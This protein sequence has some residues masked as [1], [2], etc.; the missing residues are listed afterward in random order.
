MKSFIFAF[1]VITALSISSLYSQQALKIAVV[2][3]QKAFN[4]FYK[5]K[6]ADSEMKSKVAAFEKERQEM[7]NDLNKI[8]EE[9]K[10]MHD[11]AQDKTLSEA[12]R[13]EKQKAFEA[14]AQDFQAMQRKF[15]EFQ[16]VRTK[17]LEDRSQRI[18]QS[19]IDDITK[20]ILEISSREKFTLVFDKSG[21]S[22]S[23]TN[24]LLYSQDVKDITDEVIKTINATKPQ[25]K[26]A[27]TSQ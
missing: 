4:D 27:S 10:K 9:A 17:E 6:E 7:A 2:D 25:T 15:Q 21:K 13:A 3:L 11:A 19:I 12:A 14:K 8:G 18:R 16:Y 1:S 23:G 22:L 26:A 24:V 20:T 5:T